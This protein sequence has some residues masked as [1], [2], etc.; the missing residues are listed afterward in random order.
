[1]G[2]W[3]HS[4]TPRLTGRQVADDGR[5][6]CSDSVSRTSPPFAGS[7]R[8]SRMADVPP[9]TKRVL[10]HERL[11]AVGW[12]EAAWP[13]DLRGEPANGGEVRLTESEHRFLPSS[14]T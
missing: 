4:R 12:H 14:A 3:H 6:R 10:W 8:R 9:G 11:H 2:R 13:E 1:M 7:P 5:K